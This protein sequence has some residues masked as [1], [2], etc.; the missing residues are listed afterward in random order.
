VNILKPIILA[1]ICTAIVFV[2]SGLPI[3]AADPHEDPE[4][5]LPVFSGIALFNYYSET[6]DFVLAKNPHEVTAKMEKMPF[7]NLPDN[8]TETTND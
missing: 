1:I 7:A 8:L 3:Q 6:L 2:S 4:K 5:T